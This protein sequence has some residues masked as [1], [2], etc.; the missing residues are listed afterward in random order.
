M[1]I[2]KIKWANTCELPRQ[3]LVPSNWSKALCLELGSLEEKSEMGILFHWRRGLR[4]KGK[5]DKAGREA[6]PKSSF[7]LLSGGA[8]EHKL[9]QRLRSNW[10]PIQSNLDP[11]L[12]TLSLSKSVSHCLWVVLLRAEE[13]RS[14]SPRPGSSYLAEDNS[15]EKR[16]PVG[17]QQ[18]IFTPTV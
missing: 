9:H 8:L 5:Q 16:A 2:V 4:K 12:C 7:S 11:V 15:L 14:S 17:W 13:V 3:C 1:V 18:P 10:D 6:L